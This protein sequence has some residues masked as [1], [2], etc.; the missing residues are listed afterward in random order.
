MASGPL[1]YRDFRIRGPRPSI[2]MKAMKLFLEEKFGG[3]R[4]SYFRVIVSGSLGST[5]Y[6][7]QVLISS[8][9]P[10]S[11]FPYLS[12]YMDSTWNTRRLFYFV[13]YREIRILT[14]C[15]LAAWLTTQQL[16]QRLLLF[17]IANDQC[18]KGTQSKSSKSSN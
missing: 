12:D 16:G 9:R 3:K 8:V 18:D 10:V 15:S 6:L 13:D 7:C 11:P 5:F 1:N 17:M 14:K 2:V 4:K